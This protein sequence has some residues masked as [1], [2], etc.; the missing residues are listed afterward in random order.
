[1][2]ITK[3][4]VLKIILGILI[5]GSVSSCAQ[6][7]EGSEKHSLSLA[8]EIS[9]PIVTVPPTATQHSVS[10]PPT[11]RIFPTISP[12]QKELFFQQILSENC[13]LPCY[14][15]IFPGETNIEVAERNLKELGFSSGHLTNPQNDNY[16]TYS[17]QINFDDES[18]NSQHYVY[19]TTQETRVE[20]VEFEIVGQR[21]PLLNDNWSVYSTKHVFEQQGLPSRMFIHLGRLGE[22]YSALIVY[23]DVGVVIS[24][25]GLIE[26]ENV[27]FG[28]FDH[29]HEA[30]KVI[31]TRANSELGLYRE[32]DIAPDG[33]EHWQSI[34][35]ILGTSVD[36][37]YEAL[38]TEDQ[39]CYQVLKP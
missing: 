20:R 8:T 23:E 10:L 28:S 24:N 3:R 14:L 22:T 19:L 2:N 39:V 13:L 32:D 9:E 25:F 26:N 29:N 18:G 12:H 36:E 21:H 11:Q 16:K 1:M 34:E 37:I 7:T 38:L 17:Y 27:C 15:G 35:K 4:T 31:A 6:P 5:L 33:S 30:I